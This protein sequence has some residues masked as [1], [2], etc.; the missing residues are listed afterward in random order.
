MT[1]TGQEGYLNGRPSIPARCRRER[2]ERTAL[3]VA[4]RTMDHQGLLGLDDRATFVA[5][6]T[7][8]AMQTYS[9]MIFTVLCSDPQQFMDL[10]RN[11]KVL[12]LYGLLGVAQRQR[13]ASGQA[14][15]LRALTDDQ[16]ATVGRML[17]GIDRNAQDM[18]PLSIVGNEPEP[19]RVGLVDT[20]QTE[21][22]EAFPN[23][24]PPAGTMAM[25]L[26]SVEVAVP[27]DGLIGT[28]GLTADA[29]GVEAAR[30][31]RPDVFPDIPVRPMATLFRFGSKTSVVFTF[32]L[33][34]ELEM[35]KTIEIVQYDAHSKPVALGTLPRPFLD[36]YNKSLEETRAAFKDMKPGDIPGSGR[37]VRP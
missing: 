11:E 20:L 24:L 16:R 19:H 15:P 17:Y 4:L 33:S 10:P 28:R 22:T 7:P 3:G 37:T 14:I 35:R 29:L 1:F 31:E 2:V 23:G 9:L 27:A 32:R 6:N 18:S 36:A 5:K 13:L 30:H 12:R 8:S 34:Q 26:G 21:P 25:T